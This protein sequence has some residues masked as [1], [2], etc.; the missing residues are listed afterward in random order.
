M[1]SM[2]IRDVGTSLGPVQ[3]IG[4]RRVVGFRIFNQGPGALTDFEIWSRITSDMDETIGTT[5]MPEE[6][7]SLQQDHQFTHASAL[8][9]A[10]RQSPDPITLG[11]GEEWGAT[12]DLT[13]L[14]EVEI[15][16]AAASPGTVLVQVTSR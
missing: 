2:A 15:R 13:Y 16:A 1:N 3:K 8:L 7:W 9:R 10:V 12:L 14:G 5:S 11:V 4:G 6:P